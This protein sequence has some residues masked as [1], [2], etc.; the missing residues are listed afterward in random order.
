MSFGLSSRFSSTKNT[1]PGPG[2]YTPKYTQATKG[3]TFSKALRLPKTPHSDTPGPGSYNPIISGTFNSISRTN[4]HLT[5]TTE[6]NYDSFSDSE[7][8]SQASSNSTNTEATYKQDAALYEAIHANKQKP[9]TDRHMSG[10]T[11]NAREE[12]FRL[13]ASHDITVIGEGSHEDN[14]TADILFDFGNIPWLQESGISH[15]YVEHL[16]PE[17]IAAIQTGNLDVARTHLDTRTYMRLGDQISPSEAFCRFVRG[18]QEAGIIVVSIEGHDIY[19]HY[20]ALRIP[21]LNNL[22]V[23]IITR[24]TPPG[25]KALVYVGAAHTNSHNN[26]GRTPGLTEILPVAVEIL[27]VE[28]GAG[29]PI[30][31]VGD[32]CVFHVRSE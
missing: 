22:A 25:G 5:Q 10:S 29:L 30:H 6:N 8:P 3:G 23:D 14:H 20:Q 9:L 15:I 31:S 21:N 27:I 24:E 26:L 7:T 11:A 13:I 32:G 17:H 16:Y 19:T 1:T 4:I 28:E 18:C 12:M 2:A